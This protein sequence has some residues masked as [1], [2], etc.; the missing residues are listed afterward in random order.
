MKTFR[1]NFQGINL[2]PLVRGRKSQLYPSASK[3][4]FQGKSICCV[5]MEAV[6]DQ[7]SQLKGRLESRQPSPQSTTSPPSP[8]LALPPS[9]SSSYS[10]ILRPA[11]QLFSTIQHSNT[12][13]ELPGN[14][15]FPQ[16]EMSVLCL[17]KCVKKNLFKK[18]TVFQTLSFSVNLNS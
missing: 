2:K 5:L 7:N 17:Q 13:L 14:G 8:P 1:R 3:S 15:N 4:R 9:C 12:E 10:L 16:I 11:L 6:R 18:S